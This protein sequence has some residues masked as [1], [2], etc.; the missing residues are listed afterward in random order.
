MSWWRK[1]NVTSKKGCCKDEFNWVQME[2]LEGCIDQCSPNSKRS[3]TIR[4]L[5]LEQLLSPSYLPKSNQC[6]TNI[7]SYQ[8][9]LLP[10][11]VHRYFQ[12]FFARSDNKKKS[13]VHP[14]FLSEKIDV[15]LS[16]SWRMLRF[17]LLNYQCM[18]ILEF[19]LI[20]KNLKQ[21][22]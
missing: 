21:E 8:D 14:F 9:H 2:E 10:G 17:C 15:V 12:S 6:W 13:L 19:S 18:Q 3:E 20:D 1:K 16:Y 5:T 7:N 4:V 11:S 22:L